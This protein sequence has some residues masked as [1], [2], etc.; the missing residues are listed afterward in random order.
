MLDAFL[1]WLIDKLPRLS[2]HPVAAKLQE[3]AQ[4]LAA[5]QPTPEVRSPDSG[6]TA[7]DLMASYEEFLAQQEWELALDTLAELG[8]TLAPVP[9]RFW[10]LLAEA[11]AQMQL[12]ATGAYWQQWRPAPA[13]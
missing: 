4:L 8:A 7:Q 11:A 12:P 5:S 6:R 1:A 3:A 9:A 13:D 2:P 10:E